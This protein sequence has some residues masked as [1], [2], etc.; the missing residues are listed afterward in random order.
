LLSLFVLDGQA[1][2]LDS[3]I[4]GRGLKAAEKYWFCWVVLGTQLCGCLG[5]KCWKLLELID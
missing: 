1:H 5:W 3:E 2:D 4:S